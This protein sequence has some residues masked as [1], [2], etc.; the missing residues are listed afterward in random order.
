MSAGL[1]TGIGIDLSV[2]GS[3]GESLSRVAS[4]M[5]N[6]ENRRRKLFEQLHQR[7][8]EILSTLDQGAQHPRFTHKEA[9]PYHDRAR[10]EVPEISRVG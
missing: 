8:L 7:L 4:M 10:R 2:F 3:I 1:D 5:E 6:R 9:H